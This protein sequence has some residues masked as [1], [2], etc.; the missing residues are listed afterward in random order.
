MRRRYLAV[1]RVHAVQQERHTGC[2]WLRKMQVKST[3]KYFSDWK[4]T[5]LACTVF[6]TEM[7]IPVSIKTTRNTA[8]ERSPAPTA[9][10]T[11]VPSQ[12]PPIETLYA[13]SVT[14]MKASTWTVRSMVK[15]DIHGAMVKCGQDLGNTTNML[16]KAEKK[17]DL[18]IN[19]KNGKYIAC[20]CQ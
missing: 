4:S 16:V 15:G 17:L 10:Y 5:N 11:K 8:K 14:H 18:W 3:I 1:Q 20:C 13:V 12:N 6:R 19:N 9:T 2:P 7:F